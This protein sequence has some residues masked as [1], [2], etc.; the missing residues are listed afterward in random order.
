[1]SIW[2]SISMI[3]FIHAWMFFEQRCSGTFRKTGKKYILWGY[4]F[5]RFQTIKGI[6]RKSPKTFPYFVQT[7]GKSE[8]KKVKLLLAFQIGNFYKII[9]QECYCF[10]FTGIDNQNTDV[11]TLEFK[12]KFYKWQQSGVVLTEMCYGSCSN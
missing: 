1:M 10:S 3:F 9:V 8:A 7:R 11:P 4:S 12:H 5:C 2:L 6:L